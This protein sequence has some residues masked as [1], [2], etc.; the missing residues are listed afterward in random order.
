MTGHINPGPDYSAAY[1]VIGTDSGLADPGSARHRSR[2]R[3]ARLA[4]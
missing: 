3:S 1:V 2:G 4:R